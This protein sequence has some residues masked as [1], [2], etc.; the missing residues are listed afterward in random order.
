M[1]STCRS[2]SHPASG[3]ACVRYLE[4]SSEVECAPMRYVIASMSVGRPSLS[5]ISRATSVAAYTA[6]M[7]FPSI[8]IVGRPYAGPRGAMPSERY[9]S[10]VR[11]EMA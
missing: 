1:R 9:C 2:E 3:A 8:R 5:A 6:K 7:S 10:S 4:S 11:V